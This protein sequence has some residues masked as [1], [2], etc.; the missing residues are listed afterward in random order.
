MFYPKKTWPWK[1]RLGLLRPTKGARGIRVDPETNEKAGL[2]LRMIM[3]SI[4][5][6]VFDDD[7]QYDLL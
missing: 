5:F 4:I 3:M 6:I 1:M 2:W 7:N